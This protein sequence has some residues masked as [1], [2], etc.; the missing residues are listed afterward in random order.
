M[1]N[2]MRFNSVYFYSFIPGELQ[3]SLLFHYMKLKKEDA[4]SFYIPGKTYI[5]KYLILVYFLN[6]GINLGNKKYL[7]W[8]PDTY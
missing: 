6:Y 1:V 8:F 5:F 7:L 4:K 2:L 3:S